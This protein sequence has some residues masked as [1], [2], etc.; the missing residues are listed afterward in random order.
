[1]RTPVAERGRDPW[2]A[3]LELMAQLVEITSIGIAQMRLRKPIKVPRPNKDV[4]AKAA[5]TRVER[6]VAV[7]EDDN[8]YRAAIRAFGATQPSRMREAQDATPPPRQQVAGGE[9][10]AYRAAIAR[11]GATQPARLRVVRDGERSES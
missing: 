9:S 10:S 3:E 4:A 1:M 8:P 5:T 7:G 11:F 2:T 6:A